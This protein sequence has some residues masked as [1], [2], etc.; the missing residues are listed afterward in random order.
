MTCIDSAYVE[1]LE[2]ELQSWRQLNLEMTKGLRES[3]EA[4]DRILAQ[5]KEK[6]GDG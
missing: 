1:G 4:L 3:C 5:M 2:E 6:F